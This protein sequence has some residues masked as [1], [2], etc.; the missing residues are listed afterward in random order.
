MASY[1]NHF[2]LFEFPIYSCTM[3]YFC[4]CLGLL[5]Q[6]EKNL[7]QRPCQSWF[8]SQSEKHQRRD[9][10]NFPMKRDHSVGSVLCSRPGPSRR[11]AGRLLTFKG[12]DHRKYN[13]NISSTFIAEEGWG[14]SGN[15]ASPPH[16]DIS[17]IPML[18]CLLFGSLV[19]W[20]L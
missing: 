8:I 6:I 18:E 1:L 20:G 4:I 14:G 16:C 11:K 17:D 7:F 10:Y 13:C 15:A 5:P 19:L 3:M 2:L 9:Q 12:A